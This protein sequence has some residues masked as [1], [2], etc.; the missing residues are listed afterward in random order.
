M[1]SATLALLALLAISRTG[2]SSYSEK[3]VD[4]GMKANNCAGDVYDPCG[5]NGDCMSGMCH[6][7]NGAG[8]TVCT[9]SCS[10][11]SPCPVDASGSNGFCNNMGNCKPAEANTC[12]SD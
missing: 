7:Y 5:S 8:I 11:S 12:G 9:T 3:L 4:G 2:C 6:D 10:A 1:R